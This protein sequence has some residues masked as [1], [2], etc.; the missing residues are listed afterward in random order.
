MYRNYLS[1]QGYNV[2]HTSNGKDSL[3][4]IDSDSPAIVL[5]DLQLPDMSGM[6][7]LVH[8]RKQ[9]L[10]I[11]VIV[12]TAN[13]TV[14]M[15]VEAM[16]EGAF[17]YIV[18]PFDA[19][20]LLVTLGNAIE[21]QLLNGMIE[22]YRQTDRKE[23]FGYIGNSLVMQTVYRIISSAA[24]SKATVFVTGESGTGKE[25]CAAALHSESPRKDRPFI[26]LNCAAIP[27]DLMESEIFGH[28]K[29]AF[30]GAV[31]AREGAAS[32]A[33]G[34]TLFL[35]EICEM[36]MDLQSK[37]LRFVQTGT[38]QKVGSSN[39]EDVD[40]RFV[41]ATNRDPLK[42]V[43]EGRFRE[44]LY[45]RLHVVPIE[46][47]PLRERDDDAVLIANKFLLDYSKEEGKEFERFAPEVETII[48]NY[49]WPGNVRQLQNV[50]RNTVVLN[51]GKIVVP[52]ML[53][54]LPDEINQPDDTVG[55]GIKVEEAQPAESFNTEEKTEI[56]E[57]DDSSDIRP[58]W[59]VEKDVI[60]KA[61]VKCGNN[62]PKAA[63]L[64]GVSA[65]TIYRK[66]MGW[67]EHKTGE[68]QV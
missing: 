59:M 15:A 49:Y 22:N 24:S 67:N 28:T 64:L 20:R 58:L 50:I 25:L 54:T 53:P 39:L 1:K 17:D 16:R 18:K 29:G 12:I 42:E 8:I 19:D 31:R 11:A 34:G 56:V 43:R 51:N 26:T 36:D 33:N 47:P 35:D 46:L 27:K 23:Y 38:I 32:M 40:V 14:E 55:N 48:R 9:Q 5:L 60:E 21:F 7:I 37:I 61:L 13:A 4:I 41:C 2:T 52:S 66:K 63:A 62:I 57:A 44:D 6:D 30:T 3:R 65:S 10:P 68:N 45:Y